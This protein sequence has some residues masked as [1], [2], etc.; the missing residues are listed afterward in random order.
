[1]KRGAITILLAVLVMAAACLVRLPSATLTAK[2]PEKREAL[3]NEEGRP[4]LTDPDSYYHVRLVNADLTTGQF[5]T[6][7]LDDGTDWDTLSFYPEGRS[8]EYQPGLIY[9]TEGVW[10]V[11]HGLFG[12]DLYAVEFSLSAAMSAVTALA[13]GLLVACSP[14]FVN[15]TVFG[16]FDTDMFVLLMDVLL[17][18]FLAEAFRA[19][20]FRARLLFSAGFA[21]TAALYSRCWTAEGAAVVAGAVLGAGLLFVL[22]LAIT[23]KPLLRGRRF[24]KQEPLTWLLCA[25][26]SV[27]VLLA[28]HGTTLLDRVL[29]YRTVMAGIDTG[30]GV[31]PN[32]LV[33]INELSVPRLLPKTIKKW[34]SARGETTIVGGVGGAMAVLACMGGLGWCAAQ[35]FRRNRRPDGQSIMGTEFGQRYFKVRSQSVFWRLFK[36]EAAV[37]GFRPVFSTGDSVETV[38]VFRIE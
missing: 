6:A 4:Y 18:L 15:R 14:A 33:S 5:G 34:F 31:L 9:L 3:T 35:C 36:E 27:S 38:R 13:A 10:K 7:R 22:A 30:G 17:V 25:V 2:T 29:A 37:A 20:A 1:M 21:L 23:P 16:R 28:M 32:L 24:E 19:R 11:L 26:L 8:A 12:T